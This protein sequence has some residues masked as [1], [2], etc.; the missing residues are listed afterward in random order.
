MKCYAL[1]DGTRV[2]LGSL[3]SSEQAFLRALRRMA[4]QK[5]S[6]FEIAR[7]AVGPGSPALGGRQTINRHVAAAPIYR[8]AEDIATRAGIKQELI[9][10]PE[11][12]HRRAEF[13]T[14]G[15]HM[16]ATQ[17][18]AF[19]SISRAA[20]H[21]AVNAGTLKALRIGNVTVINKQSALAYRQRREAARERLTEASRTTQDA[22][23]RLSKRA[24]AKVVKTLGNT[25]RMTGTV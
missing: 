15:S 23:S 13:P 8:V 9:L 12:E 7:A 14:D 2:D 16:S 4:Q 11:F 22:V 10:A 20:V 21:K 17:A 19:I 5:I 3:S 1:L 24:E 18:A 6:Y 25:Q